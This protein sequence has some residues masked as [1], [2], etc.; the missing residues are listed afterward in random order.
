MS[1]LPYISDTDL[2]AA[3]KAVVDC[4]VKNQAETEDDMYK[5]VIDPFAAIFDGAMQ[6][7]NLEEWSK[8]ERARQIQKT[9]QNQIGYFH[10]QILGR[11][12]GWRVLSKGVD[13][14]NDESK[15]IAEIKNKYNT[16]KSSDKVGVY[17]Y[18]LNCLNEP[19]YQDFTAYYVEIIPSSRE[20]YNKAFTPSDRETETNRPLNE[21][22]RRISG[23]AF[24]QL[25]TGYS[26]A[27]SMLFDV[28]P[29]V[30]SDV[31]QVKKLS[32]EQQ[33]SFR[34]LFDRSY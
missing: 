22:I 9:V 31:S 14:C 13:I 11:I 10:Q 2:I 24:Y 16:V 30:I 29:E 27:L 7:F 21:K 5:N 4:I 33:A 8:K 34:T 15:I 32:Q 17:D 26:G 20:P 12:T 25:A 28:L 23:Q 3:V 18:L 6:G 19:A 1:Y